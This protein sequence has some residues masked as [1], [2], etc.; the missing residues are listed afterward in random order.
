MNKKFKI[1]GICLIT[2][3]YEICLITVIYEKCVI[4]KLAKNLKFGEI[5]KIGNIFHPNISLFQNI[6]MSQW[7]L[8]PDE[9]NRIL[10]EDELGSDTDDYD[11]VPDECIVEE[12]P[13][14]TPTIGRRR[15]KAFALLRRES[16][17]KRNEDMN[18][19]E[20]KKTN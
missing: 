4:L 8:D 6:N 5:Y 13:A 18:E 12:P 2:V 17:E 15:M 1:Y 9:V 7:V 14:P 3:I 11:A 19:Y 20:K 10:Q 16:A